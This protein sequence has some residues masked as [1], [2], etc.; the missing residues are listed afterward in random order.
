MLNGRSFWTLL[1]GLDTGVETEM[2]S[3]LQ[4]G[5]ECEQWRVECGETNAAESGRV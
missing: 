3:G 4:S 5:T 1:S 2:E